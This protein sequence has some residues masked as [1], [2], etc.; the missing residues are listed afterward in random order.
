MNDWC[1]HLT[2]GKGNI[3]THLVILI[4]RL[5]RKQILNFLKSLDEVD[6]FNMFL[7]I[8]CEWFQLV[9]ENFQVGYPIHSIHHKVIFEVFLRGLGEWVLLLVWFMTFRA[10]KTALNAFSD[11]LINWS[12]N[13]ILVVVGLEVLTYFVWD[14]VLGW[15]LNGYIAGLL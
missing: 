11:W 12:F 14:H 6:I 9:K 2:V 1:F 10:N 8:L 7:L 4:F 5:Q 15:G 3:A 13:I